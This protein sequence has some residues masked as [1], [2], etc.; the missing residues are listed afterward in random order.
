MGERSILS[1]NFSQREM[2]IYAICL[3]FF[4][5]ALFVFNVT[6][7]KPKLSFVNLTLY[8]FFSVF[9]AGEYWYILTRTKKIMLSAPWVLFSIILFEVVLVFGIV[10]ILGRRA[11]PYV[12]L[13]AFDGY[14]AMVFVR[15]W[16]A[17]FLIALLAAGMALGYT[18][19][20]GWS[21][22]LLAFWPDLF[23][24]GLAVMSAEIFA[25]QWFQREHIEELHEELEVAHKQLRGYT[26]KAEEVAMMQERTRLA[27]E[28]HDTLGHSLTALDV[29]LALL[30]ALPDD[31][32]EERDGIVERA[33]RLVRSGL[34]DL[35]R[36][37]KALKPT[38]LETM[39][40]PEAIQALVQE[41]Q[42]K[43]QTQVNWQMSG[44]AYSL[45]QPQALLLYY[46]AREA[47]T[48]I[49]RHAP[50]TPAATVR[51]CFSPDEIVLTVRNLPS[52]KNKCETGTLPRGSGTG[53]HGLKERVHDLA[54][55]FYS[56]WN[57]DGN[58]VVEIRL[59]GVGG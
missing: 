16:L 10:S 59:P 39:T 8:A 57:A 14:L 58:Y 33:S 26:R 13:L 30:A 40:L 31:Q 38:V 37:V 42:T 19:L 2:N 3:I 50:D 54:G 18:L 41:Y 48:N 12:F 23:W 29:Q 21:A 34:V 44:E 7:M 51:L 56:G 53:L 43:K 45:L 24:V 4:L 17:F 52:R 28:I 49:T 36:A 20:W 22:G 55:R 11:S 25:R 1:S 15:R 47:L 46:A 5:V 6:T 9:L 27:H 32:L 35:R